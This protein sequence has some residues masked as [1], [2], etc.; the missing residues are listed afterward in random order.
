MSLCKSKT[1][2]AML[3]AGVVLLLSASGAEAA[4]CKTYTTRETFKANTNVMVASG[5]PG[6]IT[7][8]TPQP[9]ASGNSD[10]KVNYKVCCV[11]GASPCSSLIT[12]SGTDTNGA[13][14]SYNLTLS[15]R[16]GS[17]CSVP[18]DDLI[19]FVCETDEC[20]CGQVESGTCIYDDADSECASGTC[21][22]PVKCVPAASTWGLIV[23]ALLVCIFGAVALRRRTVVG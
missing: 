10:A 2:P 9:I 6:C 14:L 8:D 13:P 17:S 22:D 11:A 15:C 3:V 18:Q 7:V 20:L 21:H 5:T 12:V 19:G 16:N 4:R 1:L 23:L